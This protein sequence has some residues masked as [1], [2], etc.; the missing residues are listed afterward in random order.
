M[1]KLRGVDIKCSPNA[2]TVVERLCRNGNAAVAQLQARAV[3]LS[4]RFDL[5]VQCLREAATDVDVVM[6]PV[7]VPAG[8]S[9]HNISEAHLPCE[10]DCLAEYRS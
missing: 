7:L 5:E 1:Q 10:P 4:S 3:S 8:P 6:V 9:Q 2:G